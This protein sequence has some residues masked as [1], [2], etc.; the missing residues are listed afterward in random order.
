MSSELSGVPPQHAHSLVPSQTR[1]NISFIEVSRVSL[2]NAHSILRNYCTRTQRRLW[3]RAAG[4]SAWP[5]GRLVAGEIILHPIPTIL[6]WDR[7][8]N[9]IPWDGCKDQMPSGMESFLCCSERIQGS[10]NTSSCILNKS[11]SLSFL[12]A[13]AGHYILSVVLGTGKSKMNEIESLPIKCLFHREPSL[14]VFIFS[15]DSSP[16]PS[17]KFWIFQAAIKVKWMIQ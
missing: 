4:N 14:C 8:K 10:I 9:C 6:V 5:L 17:P 16:P 12:W 1:G 7:D 11:G 3:G 13:S 15:W 2:Y